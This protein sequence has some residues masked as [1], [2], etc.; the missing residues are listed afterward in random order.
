MA[1]KAFK[2]DETHILPLQKMEPYRL[3]FEYLKLAL[4]DGEIEVDK[5]FYKSWG[6]VEN[7]KFND[8]WSDNWRRLFA[9]EGQVR[10]IDPSNDTLKGVT[11]SSLDVRIPL[12]KPLK[13]TI[14]DIQSL[15]E[16]NGASTRLDSAPKGRFFLQ[17]DNVDKGFLKHL[18]NARMNLRLYEYWLS[19]KDEDRDN[20][21]QLAAMDWFKWASDRNDQIRSKG[22]KYELVF[23]PIPFHTWCGYL[24]AKADQRGVYNIDWDG[25]DPEEARRQ[26]NRYIR[27]AR[28][29]AKNVG[30]GI[31]PGSY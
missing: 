27:K 30:K 5:K 3:W 12:G 13:Q 25:G 15:L 11:K 4:K 17:P 8:W 22:W 19:H 9:V 6:D 21:V 14:E 20:R 26:V 2:G 7:S 29:L 23:I 10:I 1:R 24:S 16:E 31:F 28:N 18:R